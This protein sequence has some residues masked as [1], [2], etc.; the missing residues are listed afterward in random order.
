MGKVDFETKLGG[1]FGIVAC[2]AIFVEMILAGFTADS[3]VGG[4]KDISGT[5]VAILVLVVAVRKI[6]PGYKKETFGSVLAEEL[7]DFEKRSQPLVHKAKDYD[8]ENGYRYYLITRM[9]RILYAST[10]EIE[11]IKN[12]GAI[13]SGTM[14]GKFFDL[15]VNDEIKLFFYLNASTFKDRAKVEGKDYGDVLA[16][17]GPAISNCINKQSPG[18]YEATPSKDGKIITISF[19][20]ELDSQNRKPE[21]AREIAKLINYVLTLYT[22]AT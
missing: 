10:A 15:I 17:L 8:R 5:M 6:R 22:I 18:R 9:D 11:E 19:T 14:N 20:K 16:S 1:F 21:H 2:L 7:E 3:I 4:V 12:K 13:N